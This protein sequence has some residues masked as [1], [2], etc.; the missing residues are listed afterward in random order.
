MMSAHPDANG[1]YY[2][3]DLRPGDVVLVV[4]DEPE[5]SKWH[6]AG[7]V[8]FLLHGHLVCDYSVFWKRLQ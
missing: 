5:I 4:H 7:S 6:Q 8:T 1:N 2:E 3:V